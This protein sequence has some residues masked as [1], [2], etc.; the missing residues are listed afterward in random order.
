MNERANRDGNDP[1]GVGEGGDT[2]APS[3]GAGPTWERPPRAP[4]TNTPEG[5]YF[6]V[7]G[8]TDVGLVRE[9]NEDNLMVA[10][11]NA[12]SG[13]LAAAQPFEGTV[14]ERGV[15]FA[16]CDGMGGAAAGEVAS[17]M[18]VDTLFQ[19]LRGE[20]APE[21]RDDFADRLVTSIEEAGAQIFR[22]A[23]ED[24]SRRGMGTTATVA[25]LIDKVLFV[26]QVGDSRAYLLRGGRIARISKD[27]SLVN[28]LIEAGQLTEEEADAFEH[29]NI[30]L[31]ALGTTERVSVDLTFV[32]LRRDDRLLLC[33]DGL[34]ALV[35][36]E[37]I[38]EEMA[39]VGPLPQLA[40]RLIELAKAAGGHDNVTCIL[41]DFDGDALEP[42]DADTMP[43]YQQYPLPRS[44]ER[45]SAGPPLPTAVKSM[46]P[47]AAQPTPAAAASA[48]V[49]RSSSSW[50]LAVAALGLLGLAAAITV[51]AAGDRRRALDENVPPPA[52][53]DSRTPVEVRVH[54][55]GE[56][57]ELYVNG[58]SYGP[59]RLDEA[60]LLRLLPGSYRLEARESGGIQFSKD[61]VIEPGR[62]AEVTLV[63]AAD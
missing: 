39:C 12:E 44:G 4:R 34:S 2:L 54:A 28:Q 11:L 6:E 13:P 62:P 25:G 58:R 18:A 31:Q 41:V 20:A 45:H 29:S 36:D 57:G 10:E 14:R 5:L 53:A 37:M 42:P 38:R 56:P 47:R 15:A 7:F 60:V 50:R 21:S 30:I 33:S 27:Q 17:Q 8:Q 26:G 23:K 48:E 3:P 40:D 52:Y 51:I 43:F 16:V 61:I 63:R 19:T 1:S 55:S 32:E 59:L 9:H 24:R 49:S 35:H 22:A 46:L